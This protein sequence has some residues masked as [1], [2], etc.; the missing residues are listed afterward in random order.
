MNQSGTYC[1]LTFS[2]QYENIL[3]VKE[4]ILGYRRITMSGIVS[5]SDTD[6]GSVETI[7]HEHLSLFKTLCGWCVRKIL[8]FDLKAQRVSVSAEHLHQFELKKH[9]FL[10][11]TVT[12]N[13]TWMHYFKVKAVQYGMHH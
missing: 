1:I 5:N 10:E 3:H 4:L 13:E 12:C 7:L 8:T 11:V 6:V 9:T 2:Q